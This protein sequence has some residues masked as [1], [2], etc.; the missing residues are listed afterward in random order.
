MKAYF[1]PLLLACIF[2]V[3]TLSIQAQQSIYVSPTGNDR[4]AGTKEAPL[5]SLPAAIKVIRTSTEQ[6][7]IL[8]LQNGIYHLEQPLTFSPD[9]LA[10]KKLRIT[11]SA[12]SDS[13]IISGNK[14][15]SL[16]WKQGKQGLWEAQ[17][18]ESFDQLWI[19]GNPRILA[20]YPNYQKDTLFNGTAEDALS[21]K[22]IKRWKNPEGGYIHSMHA[23]MWGSQHYRIMGKVKDSLIYEGGYQVSRPSKIHSTLRFVENI[24]EELDSPGEWFLD[25]NRQILYYYPLPGEN[26]DTIEAEATVTP[27]LFVI[28]GTKNE[29]VRNVCIDGITF[30]HNRRTFMEPYE[31]LMR[32]DW[33]I[34]RGAAVL[35]ENT[36]DCKINNCEFKELGG[37]AVFLSSYAYQDTVIS[38]HIHHTGGSAIC[39]V[40]D[41][42]AIRSGAYGYS[43]YIPFEQ[44]D[45][46]PGPKNKQYPRQCLIEDNLIHD[47]GTVEKQVAGVEIQIAAILTVRHNTIYDI[48]RAGINIGDGAF[49]GHLIEYNDVF[50][51]V[52]ETS[53][54]GAFN[55]WGRDRFWHPKYNEMARLT[56][57]HPELILAD[58]LYTN[59][60][61]YN[62]FRCDHGWDIDLDDGS[63]NYHIYNNV[64]LRGGIKLREGFFR[65][66]ENNILV[67]SSLHPHVWFKDSKDVVRRNLFMQP[68]YPISLN[69]WGELLDYNFFTSRMALDNVR[70]NQ[71]DTHSITGTF[72]FTDAVGGNYTLTPD[73]KVFEIGFENIPMD[74]FGVYSQR[75]KALAKTPEFPLIQIIDANNENKSYAWLGA[76][77]RIVNGLGDRSA[78]GLPD[79]RGIVIT[80]VEKG[81]LA[82]KAGLSRNDVIRIMADKDISTIEEVFALTEENRWKGK[83]FVTIIRNQTEEK[84][85]IKF[86]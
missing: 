60:L 86:K 38:N 84:I 29:P 25:K 75:L 74:R 35:F 1:P 20:R 67:N 33:G 73:S 47:L 42:S 52:L 16:Q 58:A 2:F 9:I 49:G 65:K 79:E 21:P 27:H 17:T 72:D 44:M 10:G 4:N 66:V 36:E 34:Y 37:N 31:M 13:V 77:I 68:Y 82:D 39:M 78:F 24:R 57:E 41:T 3:T 14:K 18:E 55:S 28:R 26:M 63:S 62:R 15:L 12:Q 50:N 45:R 71:T 69:G 48:P 81:S 19:D 51:T 32:S 22:R 6:D 7:I 23:G 70:K 83:V 46:T 59:I 80:N 11:A 30:T 61:R 5:A 85:Q 64:C 56:D 53:D 43:K 76:T 40:G 8:F 54:H